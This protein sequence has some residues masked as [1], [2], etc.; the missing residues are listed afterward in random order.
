MLIMWTRDIVTCFFRPA[1]LDHAF[2]IIII[3]LGLSVGLTHQNSSY[4]DSDTKET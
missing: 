1:R 4:R 3:R 2:I